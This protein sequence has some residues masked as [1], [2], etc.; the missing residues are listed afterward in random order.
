MTADAGV[1]WWTTVVAAVGSAVA[2]CL[3]TLWAFSRVIERV[4]ERGRRASEQDRQAMLGAVAT[5]LAHE[6]RNPLSTMRMHLQLL[7]EEWREPITEREH[8]SHK[9]VEGLLREVDRL[10]RIL[11]GFLAFA[12]EHR[13]DR[14][15]VA[16]EPFFR[17]IADFIAPRCEAAGIA[18]DTRISRGLPVLRADPD[19]LRQAVLNLLLNAIE[20]TERGGRIR[21]EVAPERD[22]LCIEV[23]DTGRG[24]E[25]EVA[26]RMWNLYFST[27]PGGTG[28]GLP[29]TR[30]IVEEHGGRI[31]AD[32]A[33]GRGARFRILLPWM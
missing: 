14:R 17:E 10:E 18:L 16:V 4:R 33:P 27:K 8:R 32:S 19:L 13:L 2:A 3:A 7:E 31:E 23:A 5:G 28:I 21:L 9:R 12:M 30:K 15:D 20:A 29:M 1:P 24:I 6:I 25:P 26:Q 11:N 22:G